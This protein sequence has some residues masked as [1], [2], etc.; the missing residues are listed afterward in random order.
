MRKLKI[1]TKF[2]L[3]LRGT[4][5]TRFLERFFPPPA[6]SEGGQPTVC[7]A[8]SPFGGGRGR[9]DTSVLR[10]IALCFLL[11]SFS[12]CDR[13]FDEINKNPFAPTTTDIGPL[14]NQAI[15]TVRLGWNEQFY[16]HNEKLYQV[17][18]QASLTA[19]TFQNINLG[20]EEVWSN[21]YT[22]LAHIREIERRFEAF[23]GEEE[24]LNN[25]KAQTKILLAYKTFRITDL[26]G[27]MPFTE[28]GK[29]FQSVD[30]VRPAFDSQES[31][32]KFLLEELAW[33]VE[34]INLD[35][36]P[37]TVGGSP[38]VSYGDFDTFFEGDLRM[39]IKFANSLRLRHAVRMADKDPAYANPVIQQIL[40]D[41][42]LLIEDGEDVV[43]MP[44]AQNWLN[45]GLNW[46]FR[47]HKKLRMGSTV[48][49][50]LSETDAKDG[51]GI[52]DPRAYLFFEP[53]NAREWVPF[54]QLPAD[55][56]PQAA[57]I[58]YQQHR[59]V[60]YDF[61]GPE[62]I[63]SPLNYYMVRDEKHVPEVILTAAE[64]HFLL[65]E[66]Y[67]RG[68]GV[69][70]NPSFAEAEYTSGVVAS[71][72]F[73]QAVMVNSDAWVNKPSIL[74]IGQIFAAVNHPKLSIFAT[75]RDKLELIY[76][77]RWL[78][79]FRQP[80]EGFALLRRVG[81]VPRSG[82]ENNFLRFTYPPS[83]AEKNPENWQIQAS[84]MG[85]DQDD[86]PVWWIP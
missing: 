51:S 70:A 6:P 9:T 46:S 43:M 44:A 49:E 14:F 21:Y 37:T 79:A 71:I 24:A 77:Q 34:N 53:N 68:L 32:Y 81:S 50:E 57:G 59:D 76:A 84:Q 72:E 66:I 47:E 36:T 12:A 18:Q 42:L 8:I 26:F 35:I 16:L 82:P 30:N 85:G 7:E 54:P 13:D 41:N 39:W 69:A 80:W 63:Y 40:E 58:P 78:D 23:G 73:W 75:T 25:V 48:W 5:N 10:S 11:L 64:V 62:N 61:K 83:E 38:Y 56:T 67:Y 52:F 3:P 4:I 27:D 22:A 60:S 74:S 2:L 1:Y 17:T 20:T 15:S 86:V 19:E 31:I 55:T 65:A 45:R 29:A 28:A 33:A